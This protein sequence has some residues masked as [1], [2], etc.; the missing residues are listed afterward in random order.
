MMVFL[1]IIL[2]VFGISSVITFLIVFLI[3]KSSSRDDYDEVENAKT[4]TF[5]PDKFEDDEDET[6]SNDALIISENL[7]L[8]SEETNNDIFIEEVKSEEELD[9]VDF[10]ENTQTKLK[11]SKKDIKNKFN[12]DSSNKEELK[13]LEKTSN[14]LKINIAPRRREETYEKPVIEP[15]YRDENN[16]EII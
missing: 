11:I 15:V 7:D 12:S 2:A 6:F 13:E 14:H 1:Y 4:K 9:K 16:E 8:I 10:L 3:N 5:D